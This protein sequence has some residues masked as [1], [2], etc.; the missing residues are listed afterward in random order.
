MQNVE[1]SE[2]SKEASDKTEEDSKDVSDVVPDDTESK[3]V[4][5]DTDKEEEKEQQPVQDQEEESK[6]SN[7]VKTVEEEEDDDDDDE[8]KCI[9]ED[10]KD[11]IQTVEDD[12]EDSKPSVKSGGTSEKESEKDTGTQSDEK[13]KYTGIT[14][15]KR[16]AK[17]RTTEVVDLSSDEEQ[18]SEEDEDDESS[19]DD[20]VG[21]PSLDPGEGASKDIPNAYLQPFLFGWK[22]EVVFRRTKNVTDCD[23]YYLPPLE[24]R[25]RTR[26]A[27]RK[28]RSKADQE[29]YFEDFPDD[30]LGIANFNYVRKPPGL[31]NAAY[32]IVRRAGLESSMKTSEQQEKED[33]Y[34]KTNAKKSL[35]EVEESAGLLED[36]DSGDEEVRLICGFDPDVPVSLQAIH[37]V[38]GMNKQHD[39][40]K[41]TRDPETCCTPPLAEDTLWTNLDDDPFGVYTELGGRS[42]PTT[43]PPLRAIKLTYNE[44][45]DKI[46]Q[47]LKDVKEE[48]FKY[49]ANTKEI[50]LKEELAS[51]DYAIKKYK[52]YKSGPADPEWKPIRNHHQRPAQAQQNYMKGH[53]RFASS[54]IMRPAVERPCNIKCPGSVGILPSMQCVS[55]KNM[56]HAKCQGMIS[57]N[58]RVFRC[59]RCLIRLQQIQP[60]RP[61]LPQVQV[62]RQRAQGQS[63]SPNTSGTGASVKLKLPMIPKNGKRPIVEL[64]LRT[65]EGRYQPI[66]FRNNS[67]ITETIPRT[68]FNKA[69]SARKTLYV[70]SQQLPRLNG[71]PVFL[72]INPGAAPQPL[73]QRPPTQGHQPVTRPPPPPTGD[74]V[75]ILVRPQNSAPTTKP[76]LLNVP[77]KVA[78]KVK[79]G[80]TL[81]FSA[82]NDQKY[83]VMDSKIHPPVGSRGRNQNSAP[84]PPKQG[85]QRPRLP[86]PPSLSVIPNSRPI[87]VPPNRRGA[88]APM[89]GGRGRAAPLSRIMVR[90][91]GRGSPPVGRG[92]PGGVNR[93]LATLMNN[94]RPGLTIT[95]GPGQG[96]P[97]PAK[98]PRRMAPTIPKGANILASGEV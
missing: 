92:S 98:V 30:N 96:A 65:L 48:A 55:C 29:R 44:T 4:I 97:P 13:Q 79:V 2:D 18:E 7:E 94:K 52:N 40:R 12:D 8:V 66:K 37:H 20:E 9:D 36:S 71:K 24:S 77:R 81:S 86:L 60:K 87:Q 11:D 68:L 25:Y 85:Q 80:T 69:N 57:P 61:L 82:S 49:E 72:A 33:P 45:A 62:Q 88:M 54:L 89:P 21:D 83:I 84:V 35:K 75:S 58:L 5:A 34:R 31:E 23:I 6:E 50:E 22:R 10:S 43:P 93:S 91:G 19:E 78:L 3:D 15:P 14:R 73:I 74:Q 39:K 47:T 41:K 70:K 28:R 90:P 95:R 38:T 64:V 67:Q 56:F 76:V 1:S 32:E 46:I 17:K 27:K 26:E 53:Q 42:S 16:P 59:K 63:G 51:H